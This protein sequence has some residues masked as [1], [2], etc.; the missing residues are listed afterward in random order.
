MKNT[1]ESLK[2]I[3]ADNLVMAETQRKKRDIR[4]DLTTHQP[5]PDADQISHQTQ[6]GQESARRQV[7]SGQRGQQADSLE[8]M[9]ELR[10]AR[11]NLGALQNIN[12]VAETRKIHTTIS[13]DWLSYDY[14]GSE[15]YQKFS[16]NPPQL[17]IESPEYFEQFHNQWGFI[18]SGVKP[19]GTNEVHISSSVT[20]EADRWELLTHEKL[21][22]AS[23]LGGGRIIRWSGEDGRTQRMV[24]G[25]GNATWL[26]EG[27]TEM[28]AQELTREQGYV[29]S[30]VAYPYET[31]TSFYIQGIVISV[32][33]NEE[34]GKEIVRQ[35]YL[36]GDFSQVSMY[37]DMQLGGGTFDTLMGITPLADGHRIRTG[38]E[39]FDFLRS[40]LGA[41]L[42]S[43][44]GGIPQYLNWDENPLVRGAVD[45]SALR[46]SI[47]D[48]HNHFP[49]QENQ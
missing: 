29:P 28:H 21:H 3:A 35:A 32:V 24:Y 34:L 22:H 41:Q 9:N 38:A 16:N 40:K 48:L 36:T 26:H 17:F 47:R 42:L 6:Q 43:F 5:L 8:R 20:G 12:Y 1:T 49:L 4:D 14:L 33:G 37:V 25:S 44:E 15:I 7:E 2:R 10:R 23:D 19:W 31:A 13:T 46:R 27:M 45:G 11:D 30:Y 18:P 39:A